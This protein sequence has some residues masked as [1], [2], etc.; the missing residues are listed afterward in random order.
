MK[1][2]HEHNLATVIIYSLFFMIAFLV[3]TPILPSNIITTTSN[4]FANHVRHIYEYKLALFE[5]QFPPLVAPQLNGEMRVPVF[6][7]YS[8]TAY[9]V[10]ALFSILGLNEYN[11]LKLTIFLLSA[12]SAISLFNAF[13]L[14]LGDRKS[15]WIGALSFQLF[16]FPLIDLYSRGAVVEWISLQYA[17]I[18]FYSL[19]ALSHSVIFE[20]IN[21]IVKHFLFSTFCMALFIACHPIQTFYTGLV[22]AILLVAYALTRDY[23]KGL[24]YKMIG[25]MGLS[26]SISLLLTSW[27]WVPI[28]ESYSLIN[29]THYMG[30]FSADT[31]LF[32]VLYPW[33]H[34]TGFFHLPPQIGLHITL[35]VLFLI[36]LARTNTIF[37][38][39]VLI[40][41][42][43]LLFFI[44]SA[45]N[46]NQ[47]GLLVYLFHPMQWSYRLIITLA[48]VA[49]LLIALTQ[50]QIESRIKKTTYHIWLLCLSCFILLNSF[51]YFYQI[52]PPMNK[53]LRMMKYS[54][55]LDQI[56]SID[57]F[58]PQSTLSYT[59]SGLNY[60][61]LD[62][63]Q[64]GKLKLNK[65]LM[66]PNENV[67]FESQLVFASRCNIQVIV[68]GQAAQ[69]RQQ[70][71]NGKTILTFLLHLP[72]RLDPN[73]SIT[74]QSST[75]S[76]IISDYKFRVL[77]DKDWFHVLNNYVIDKTKTHFYAIASTHRLGLY[78]IPLHY[79]PKAK[80]CV[81]GKPAIQSSSDNYLVI[82][83]LQY[84]KNVI[85]APCIM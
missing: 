63:F 51:S 66:L 77:G 11:A 3:I 17:A 29:I 59:L 53:T 61:Q 18:T 60:S 54:T 31:T 26:F 30:F 76:A 36:R 20:K 6:Q 16:T 70:D 49:A 7:Y 5:G 85:T 47:H 45:S 41:F 24:K 58:A 57:F 21:N 12:F 42:V 35:S 75:P 79:F 37:T 14:M 64:D 33:F 43:S 46:S 19:I 2:L 25:M 28:F 1:T 82:T 10:P 32:N 84:G 40:L 50:F 27:F 22:I 65:T 9:I 23:A 71:V 62:W 34:D 72:T 68:N 80:I 39:L 38:N 15:A 48:I 55:S 4:D 13:T 69:Q 81:N 8:A 56:K 44:V 74:F 73:M 83:A 78:Q 67:V 52:H